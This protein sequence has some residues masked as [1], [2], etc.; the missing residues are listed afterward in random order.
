MSI[1][2]KQSDGPMT[3]PILTVLMTVYNGEQYLKDAV[4]SILNQ[5]YRNFHF[6]IL[7]NASTDNS[8]E[9]ISEFKDSRIELVE[10][11]ENIGHTAA[12]NR[13]LKLIDTPLVARMDADDISFKN[14]LELQINFLE[15]NKDIDILG[16]WAIE[17][18]LPLQGDPSLGRN[19]GPCSYWSYPPAKSLHQIAG[20]PWHGVRRTPRV[21]A[22]GAKVAGWLPGRWVGRCR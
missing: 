11:I 5:T 21:R 19:S 9:I 10:L 1:V 2:V 13:G 20:H 22:L 16:S 3:E 14:R 4:A 17:F 18:Q 6:L 8:R 15:E 7:D 12:L